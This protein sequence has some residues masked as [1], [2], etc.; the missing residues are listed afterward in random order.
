MPTTEVAGQ[1]IGG[2][3]VN[4]IGLMNQR[5]NGIMIAGLVAIIGVVLF[6]VGRND[7]GGRISGDPKRVPGGLECPNCRLISPDTALQCDCGFVFRGA[8]RQ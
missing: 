2:G 1:T 7:A 8:N 5:Q 6:V 3:R 4:N